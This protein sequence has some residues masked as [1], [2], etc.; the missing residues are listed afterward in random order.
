MT[1]LKGAQGNNRSFF[2]LLIIILSAFGEQRTATSFQFSAFG[3]QLTASSF[4]FSAFGK[5]RTVS[6]KQLTASSKQQTANSKQ[7]AAESVKVRRC[8]GAKVKH[9]S[10]SF[11][12]SDS[13]TCG[14]S[15]LLPPQAGDYSVK[16]KANP[17]VKPGRKR[18]TDYIPQAELVV[19]E[20]AAKRNACFGDDLL[21]L[22]AVGKAE[23]GRAGREFGI[24]HPRAIN[25]NLDTQAGWAAATIV[26]N[27]KRWE[28]GGSTALPGG[29]ERANSAATAEGGEFITFLGKRYCPPEAHRLN[30]HWEGNVK[31]W[32]SKF[33]MIIDE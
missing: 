16:S 22:L 10:F 24:L 11:F 7:Q 17:D 6:S 3:K 31:F 29:D 20:K 13:Q 26:K 25:T 2:L 1:K 27:R 28:K 8:E 14:G 19:I 23:N 4:Q 15:K 33:K 21:I 32:Y 12:L 18:L 5:Q 9:S 30:R